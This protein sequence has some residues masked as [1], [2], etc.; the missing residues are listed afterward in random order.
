[1]PSN[2]YQKFIKAHKMVPG[3]SSTVEITNTRIGSEEAGVYGASLHIGD[4]EYTEFC[5]LYCKHV[6]ENRKPEHMTERQLNDASGEYG[7]ILIDLDFRYA[8]TITSRQHTNDDI[9]N[10]IY[11]Y[12]ESLMEIINF[13]D[14]TFSVYVFEKANVNIVPEK[15]ITKDGIHIIIGIKLSHE[16]QRLLRLKV[17]EKLPT[18][19]EDIPITN[20][21]SDVIDEGI[22]QGS[23]G[24]QMYGSKK[25]MNQPYK[26]THHHEYTYSEETGDFQEP[27]HMDDKDDFKSMPHFMKISARFTGNPSFEVKESA[28]IDVA[29]KFKKRVPR[30]L[31]PSQLMPVSL[32]Q[33]V[34]IDYGQIDTMEKLEQQIELWGKSL[35]GDSDY[36]FKEI[37]DLIMILPEEYYDKGSYNKWIKVGFALKSMGDKML[38][39]WLRFCARSSVFSFADIGSRISDWQTYN[40]NNSN[41]VTELSII[42][43]ARMSNKDEFEKVCCNTLSR[44]IDESIKEYTDYSVA[45]VLYCKY[46]FDF[47]C[48]SAK[49]KIWY[50]FIDNIWKESDD[51]EFTRKAPD[52]IFKLYTEKVNELI[53]KKLTPLNE[54]KRNAEDPVELKRIEDEI[55]KTKD[56][57]TTITK[58]TKDLRMTSTQKN[59]MTQAKIL[60]YDPKFLS[61]MNKNV[62]LMAFTNGI[63]DFNLGQFREGRPD[64]YITLSTGNPYYKPEA[65]NN[66]EVI[67]QEIIEFMKQLFPDQELC[68]YMW[69]HLS[70]VLLGIN[71][72]QTFNI[73]NGAGSNGKSLL[74][75]LMSEMLGDYKGVVPTTLITQ[76]RNEIGKA[77]PEIYQLIGRRY[78]VIQEP[79]KGDQLNEGIMKEIT[80]GDPLQGRALFKDTV[81]FIPQFKLVVC[82]NNLMD[83]KSND[84][85]TWRRIRVCK[86]KSKFVD[87]PDYTPDTPYLFLKNKNLK[88]EKFKLWVPVLMNM[89]IERVMKN[90]GIIEDCNEVTEA[91]NTYR[92]EQDYISRFI[93]EK[94]RETN[95]PK[96]CIKKR[97]LSNVFK[98]WHK[99]ITG[100]DPTK[101]DELYSMFEKRYGAYVTRSGWK[102]LKIEDDEDDDEEIIETVEN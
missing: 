79:Q 23:V 63:Y 16:Y 83:I 82:T 58:I 61:G 18:E 67:K 45:L 39:P 32:E 75:D 95:N 41:T 50:Q 3:Q 84:D 72:N 64:D 9:Q 36:K 49:Q 76:K 26:M 77:S 30:N 51:A 90:K 42:Y 22:T 99:L 2:G 54:L 89:L 21:W 57:I 80:G 43:W 59:I 4:E 33:I 24:W 78:A 38:L 91:S 17:L 27:I 37:Y 11:I 25:P 46:K 15:N 12:L 31:A 86:F 8:S 97:A 35:N 20:T 87:Q 85:G 34:V 48:V 96:D 1:M 13:T 70:S 52:E 73:Y 40:E 94:I 14:N 92:N 28:V 29:N 7:P 98:Q 81:T 60:F 71:H 47:V 101:L 6:F 53:H 10:I 56:S 100:K 44:Y 66:Y 62:Y 88:S 69:E 19:L 5:D 68:E 93:N 74:V 55:V 65:I 102:N